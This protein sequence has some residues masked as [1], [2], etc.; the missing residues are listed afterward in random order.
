[1]W[2]LLWLMS[3]TYYGNV[4]YFLG[5]TPRLLLGLN[6]ADLLTDLA[7]RPKRFVGYFQLSACKS[8]VFFLLETSTS[9]PSVIMTIPPSLCT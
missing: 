9:D 6:S 7:K 8:S 2:Y 4:S 3:Q 1:M 5:F